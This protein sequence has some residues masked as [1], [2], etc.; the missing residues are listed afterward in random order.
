MPASGESQVRPSGRH[1]LL[2][3]CLRQGSRNEPSRDLWEFRGG[4]VL[5]KDTYYK[6][7]TR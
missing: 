3:A 7:V 6:Q 4:K 1:G 2:L 5:K